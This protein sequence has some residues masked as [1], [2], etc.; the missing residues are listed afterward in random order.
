[1]AELR[2]LGVTIA[3]GRFGAHMMVESE[4]DGPVTI[5]LDSAGD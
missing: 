1:M 2:S 3:G 4:N 5:Q